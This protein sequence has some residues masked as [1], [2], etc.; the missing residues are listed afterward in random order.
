MKK[1][2]VSVIKKV[3]DFLIDKQL[4]EDK[5]TDLI[6]HLTFDKMKNN[7]SVN[8]DFASE[9][10]RIYTGQSG[11]F[12]RCGQVGSYKKD[13]NHEMEKRIDEWIE[14]SIEETKIDL[15]LFGLKALQ[16]EQ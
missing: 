13:I 7:S 9:L 1:D 15:S 4:P 12:M 6:E 16:N 3:S 11:T 2:M 8:Y 14:R 5:I 10:L